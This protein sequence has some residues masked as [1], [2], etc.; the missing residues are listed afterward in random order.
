M[1]SF[2]FN[3]KKKNSN[4]FIRYSS[5]AAQMAIIIIAG[6]FFGKWLDSEINNCFPVFTL[7]FVLFSVFAAIYFA[8]KDLLKK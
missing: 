1:N 6:T 5:M 8:I 4:G 7:L 2:D 3:E